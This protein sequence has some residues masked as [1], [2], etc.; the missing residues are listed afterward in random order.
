MRNL[1]VVFLLMGTA[2]AETPDWQAHYDEAQ[3]LV[4]TGKFAE[5]IPALEALK[6][7]GDPVAQGRVDLLLALCRAWAADGYTL[8]QAPEGGA[9]HAQTVRTTGE[10]A[11]IYLD[12]VTYGV[13]TGGYLA[14]LG[15]ADSATWVVLPMLLSAGA[16]SGALAYLDSRDAFAYGHPRS[17]SAGLRIGA[18]E[19]VA[20]AGWYQAQA[21]YNDELSA[22]QTGT[23]VWGLATTGVVA[24]AL[25]GAQLR[26]TPGRAAF[27]ESG[28]FWSGAV[29]GLTAAALSGDDNQ[30]DDAFM[31]AG[32][33]ALNVG[34]GAAAWLASEVNPS[35]DRALYL[36]LGG[37][38]GGLIAGGLYLAVADRDSEPR[39]AAGLT[40]AGIA[41]GLATAWI[42]TRNLPPDPPRADGG[43]SFGFTLAPLDGGGALAVGGQF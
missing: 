35:S 28:A 32:A 19:G 39:L 23:V 41:G 25:L 9:A 37:L 40:A 24:G 7:G 26:T 31:L 4:L 1:L 33:L 21:R 12:G 30:A 34:A 11:R 22:K 16:V 2:R 10:M 17:I 3:H 13:G 5:A 27:T 36:D 14:V 43:R 29:V 20:W 8:M 15:E 6:G 18:M 38:G 42:L